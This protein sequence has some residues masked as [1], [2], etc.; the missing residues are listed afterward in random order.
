MSVQLAACKSL[1][2]FNERSPK[3]HKPNANKHILRVHLPA[4]IQALLGLKLLLA[5][6]FCYALEADCLLSPAGIIKMLS[7]TL[8]RILR[9][10]R[11]QMK[12]SWIS[13][14]V[15]FEKGEKCNSWASPNAKDLLLICFGCTDYFWQDQVH[16]LSKPFWVRL[17]I[18]RGYGLSME[19]C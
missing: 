17:Y 12:V 6:L 3:P 19:S 4:C 7:A 13:S 5:W 10:I 8:R 16:G 2:D 11:S 18:A 15:S 14:N 9:V 1:A